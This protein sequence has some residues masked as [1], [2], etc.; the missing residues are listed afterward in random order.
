MKRTTASDVAKSF[1]ASFQKK[2]AEISNLK[3]Q[4]LLYYAQGWHLALYGQPLFQDAIQAWVHGPVVPYVFREYKEYAWRPITKSV[5]PIITAD[6]GF[7]LN[8][9]IRVYG[10][11]DAVTL[12]RMTHREDPWKNARGR[13]APDEPSHAVISNSSMKTYFSDLKVG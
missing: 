1:I 4:K 8:E 11:F 6:E 2:D 7:H 9:V 12:E 10:G 5:H 3:L 13:L